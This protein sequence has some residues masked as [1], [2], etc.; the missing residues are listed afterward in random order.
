MVIDETLQINR[1]QFC[2]YMSRCFQWLTA[3]TLMELEFKDS[4]LVLMIIEDVM[5]L[6]DGKLLDRCVQ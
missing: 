3:R 1:K 6:S 2:G 5:L 4:W